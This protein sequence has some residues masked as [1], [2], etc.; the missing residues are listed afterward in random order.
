MK[1]YLYL[2]A[3]PLAVTAAAMAVA[4]ATGTM[5][6]PAATEHSVPPHTHEATDNDEIEFGPAPDVFP[7]GAEM[8][9]VPKVIRA[10]RATCSPSGCGSLT[11]MC[12]RRIGTRVIEHV[13]VISGTFIVGL[14]DT[15]DEAALLPPLEAGD[16]VTAPA[17]ANHFAT[18][19]G[20]TEVQVHAVG[21]FALTYVN[22]ED[23]PR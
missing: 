18:V 14:G 8:A 21:P 9:V 1:R 20:V 19:V 6:E 23:N 12:S 5:A 15:F 2:L 4:P 13:T 17:N 3:A 22:P 11:A 7:I 10:P 16:F